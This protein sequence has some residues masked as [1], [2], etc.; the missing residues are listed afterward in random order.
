MSTVADPSSVSANYANRFIVTAEIT[1]SKI[2]PAGFG[3]QGASCVAGGMGLEATDIGFF[4][5]TG[6]GDMAGVFVGHTGYY[7]LKSMFAKGIDMKAE[8]TSGLWLGSAA[9]CSGF[10][11]QPLVNFFTET[12]KYQFYGTALGVWA[13]CGT[14]FYAGLR[15]FRRVYASMGLPMPAPDYANLKGDALLSVSIGGATAV[16]VGTDPALVGNVF[17]DLVGVTDE[18]ADFEGMCRAGL[19]TAIGFSGSQAAF[20]VVQPGGK[21]FLDPITA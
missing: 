20:N 10:A 5:M 8:A 17:A 11:W 4:T 3:W 18:M 2:F 16:F 19:S 12:C 6:A 7:A 21:N 1:V 14:A 9:F 15:V 13:G